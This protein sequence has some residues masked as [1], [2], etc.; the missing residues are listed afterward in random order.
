[1]EINSLPYFPYPRS[2]RRCFLIYLL[3]IQWQAV[4]IKVAFNEMLFE[5]SILHLPLITSAHQEAAKWIWLDWSSLD[6]SVIK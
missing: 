6:K 4:E 1:M 3:S 5:R 2:H